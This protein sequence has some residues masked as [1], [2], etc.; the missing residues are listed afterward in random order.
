MCVMFFYLWDWS[1]NQKMIFHLYCCNVRDSPR[2]HN[3]V[4]TKASC[5]EFKVLL[6]WYFAWSLLVISFCIGDSY[7]LESGKSMFKR[8]SPDEL[9][10]T[11]WSRFDC[12]I[13]SAT[14][15]TW[16]ASPDAVISLI[17]RVK[18]CK[19]RNKLTFMWSFEAP[20]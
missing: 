3:H 18:A 13:F 4:H 20:N 16:G 5:A 10:L 8:W 9:R 17:F 6:S 7:S 1:K 12:L 19:F 15:A 14:I 11:V 2:I